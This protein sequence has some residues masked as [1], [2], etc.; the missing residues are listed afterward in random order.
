MIWY[1]LD[2]TKIG[3]E[4]ENGPLFLYSDY[5]ETLRINNVNQIDR[6]YQ[7]SLIDLTQGEQKEE[8]EEDIIYQDETKS[9]SSCSSPSQQTESDL[10]L[11]EDD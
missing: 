7:E 11:E 5:E 1:L 4:D 3:R 10:N 9:R 8:E 2:K 6:D